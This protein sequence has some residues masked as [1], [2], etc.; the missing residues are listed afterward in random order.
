M[1]VASAIA[2]ERLGKVANKVVTCNV[3]YMPKFY[4]S[5]FYRYW[6]DVSD[7]DVVKYL[8]E[9]RALK[10]RGGMGAATDDK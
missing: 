5:D 7:N 8:R 6:Y 1:P 2:F 10:F 3:G 4:V 9:W